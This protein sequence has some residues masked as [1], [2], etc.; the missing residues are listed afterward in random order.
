A[1]TSCSRLG[2]PV[3]LLDVVRLSN[4]EDGRRTDVAARR[5][6][7]QPGAFVARLQRASPRAGRGPVGS[8]PRALPALP[9]LLLEPRRVL[10]GARRRPP[11]PGGLGAR[12]PL[13]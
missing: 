10:H 12:R 5:A 1:F 6:A 8:A 2:H 3:V 13:T 11:R 9:V 4:D 7:P